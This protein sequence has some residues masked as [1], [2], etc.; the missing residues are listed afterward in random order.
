MERLWGLHSQHS[1]RTLSYYDNCLGQVASSAVI[2]YGF[3]GVV[4]KERLSGFQLYYYN[5]DATTGF[6]NTTVYNV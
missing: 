2:A 5:A 1:L 4:L 3:A 6:D